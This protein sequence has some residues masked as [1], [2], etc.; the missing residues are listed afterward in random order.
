MSKALEVVEVVVV[1]LVKVV[2]LV[3]RLQRFR[4]RYRRGS[5]LGGGEVWS[6][7]MA[8]LEVA[9]QMD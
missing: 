7:A 1:V 9:T 5:V 3:L 4:W 2:E 6:R 8:Q